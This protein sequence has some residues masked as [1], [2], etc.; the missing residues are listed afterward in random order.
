MVTPARSANSRAVVGSRGIVSGRSISVR[1]RLTSVLGTVRTASAMSRADR[2][3][4]STVSRMAGSA[5]PSTVASTVYGLSEGGGPASDGV[6]KYWRPAS[7]RIVTT[8]KPATTEITRWPIVRR[9]VPGG[10]A[11]IIPSSAKA[12]ANS[13]GDA[14][15]SE[16]CFASARRSASATCGGVSGRSV[17]IPGGSTARC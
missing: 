15:R 16:G 10:A 9:V 7:P 6:N 3:R 14:N 11:T 4:Y 8:A 17:S 1:N 5:L 2:N 12:S 13:I